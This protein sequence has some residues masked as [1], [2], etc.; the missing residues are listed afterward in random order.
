MRRIIL[1][2]GICL[3]Y[4]VGF[5][6]TSAIT[7]SGQRIILFPNGTWIA[8]D[9]LN[10]Y[11]GFSDNN[12]DIKNDFINAYRFAY[13][14]LYSDIFFESERKQKAAD[15]ATAGLKSGITVYAGNKS[16]LSWYEDLYHIAFNYLYSGVFFDTEKQK[17]S[18]EW[19]KKI[20]ETKTIF[21]PVFYN[22]YYKKYREVYKLA[23]DKIFSN[24][25]FS[26]ERKT[27]AR[28]WT[29]TFMTGK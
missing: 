13:D 2:V 26:S 7:N 8:A 12:L 9:S 25:F 24:E 1:L 21:D 5:S 29:T 10:K 19:V 20:L 23:F 14:E 16:L 15:W 11:T 17:Q 22:S 6:Q 28:N 4:N 18:N 3:V 27:K